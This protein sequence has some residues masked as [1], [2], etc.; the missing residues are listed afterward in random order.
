M[1]VHGTAGNAL[2]FALRSSIPS[3]HTKNDGGR[4]FVDH[5][6]KFHEQNVP[7]AE[8]LLDGC[9]V[10]SSFPSFLQWTDGMAVA[11]SF[12]AGHTVGVS[13]TIAIMLHEIPH[14]VWQWLT[15]AVRPCLRC[16]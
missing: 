16:Q 9:P 1:K 13:T 10:L 11:A 14:E 7:L 5:C 8:S 6:P 3:R 12:L 4:R 2:A 15:S